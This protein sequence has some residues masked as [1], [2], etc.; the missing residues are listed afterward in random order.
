MVEIGNMQGRLSPPEGGRIQFF[1]REGW[2]AEFA[3][4]AKV[5]FCSIEWLYDTWGEGHN[6]LESAEGLSTIKELSR[7]HGIAVRS[8]CAHY[9]VERPFFRA[10]CCQLDRL[11]AR[12]EWLLERCGLGGIRRV[13][14]PFLEDGEIRTRNDED[15]ALDLLRAAL[16]VAGRHGVEIHLECGFEPAGYARFLERLAAP[17]I[18]VLYDTGN[19][20]SLG[21]D[22][23]E[24][25]AAYGR[26]IG[27]VHIKDRLR[28]GGSVP[29]GVGHAD[30]PRRVR[31]LLEAGY[32]GDF[33]LEAARGEPAD[34]LAWARRNLSSVADVFASARVAVSKNSA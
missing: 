27:S 16:P 34:E 23:A 25:I 6:P 14:L 26:Q 33:I 15:R 10:T 5:G 19:S 2:R 3:L 1:P 7:H 30:L 22:V 31:A 18:K 20:A 9:F 29:L 28:G 4:A 24:E 32:R 8:L 13:V 17:A 11:A 12:L 21:Y